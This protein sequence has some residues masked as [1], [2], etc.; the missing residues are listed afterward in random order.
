MS[1]FFYDHYWR[2]TTKDIS[3]K[4][5]SFGNIVIF[6]NGIKLHCYLCYVLWLFI[7]F[8]SSIP[9]ILL[10]LWYTDHRLLM[11]WICWFMYWFCITI[12]T[13]EIYI[14]KMYLFNLHTFLLQLMNGYWF[15][16]LICQL[17][18][19]HRI[20]LYSYNTL[21]KALQLLL[22]SFI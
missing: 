3:G 15:I 14:E 21:D 4:L 17:I 9:V 22:L 10:Y 11:Y 19:L 16:I 8:V 20:V 7:K 12:L 5:S 13:Y 2:R 6:C 1:W 18:W